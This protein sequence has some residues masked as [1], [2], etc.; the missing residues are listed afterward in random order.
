MILGIQIQT[1]HIVLAQS[2]KSNTTAAAGNTFVTVTPSQSTNKTFWIST[3]HLD[4]ATTI[5][6]GVACGNCT[7]NIPTHP[8]EAFPDTTLL[9]G[10]GLV[11]R[12]PYK[13]EAWADIGTP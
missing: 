4:G 12:P 11:L 8:T 5:H 10:P 13:V 6:S 1:Y 7:Q 2:A 9:A 3:V